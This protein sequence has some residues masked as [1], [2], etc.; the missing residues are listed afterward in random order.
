MTKPTSHLRAAAASLAALAAWALASATTAA[1]FKASPKAPGGENTPLHLGAP[2]ATHASTSGGSS[3]VR[4]IVGLAIVLAVI[5]GLYWILKQVKAGRDPN[6]SKGNLASVAALQLGSGRSLHLVR[7][8][9][10][11]VL[12]GSAEH[13]L[14]PI[15]RYTEEQARAGGLLPDESSPRRPLAFARA[16]LAEQVAPSHPP[17]VHGQFTPGSVVPGNVVS[18]PA[19]NPMGLAPAGESLLGRL[20]SWTVRP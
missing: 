8:G 18:G 17:A 5:W 19:P 3:L 6:V 11:Y 7:A 1:A 13:G 2:S 9:N 16:L 14:I 20:R 10:D 4:T 15:Q 12:I